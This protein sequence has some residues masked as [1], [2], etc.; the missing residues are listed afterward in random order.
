MDVETHNDVVNLRNSTVALLKSWIGSKKL[1]EKTGIKISLNNTSPSIQAFVERQTRSF[2][3]VYKGC[4]I[5]GENRISHYCHIIPH[6]LGG[7]ADYA[8]YVYLCP[9]HH[10]LFDHN[11]LSKEEWKKLDF[12]N[13]LPAVKEYVKKVRQVELKRFWKDPE[14]T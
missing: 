7:P 9:V 2:N 4:E 14:E 1:E 6:S 5:C 12:S 8:N 13:K 10:H 11:R 3:K